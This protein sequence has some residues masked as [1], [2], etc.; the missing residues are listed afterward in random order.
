MRELT[1]FNLGHSKGSRVSSIGNASAF[2]LQYESENKLDTGTIDQP[3]R[4]V[5]ILMQEYGFLGEPQK[6]GIV[7]HQS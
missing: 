7:E 4:F 5:Q 2:V 3:K 1:Y 6:K